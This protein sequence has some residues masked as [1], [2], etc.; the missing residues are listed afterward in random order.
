L[1]S[2]M[3][4][5]D[6]TGT[7]QITLAFGA[8]CVRTITVTAQGPPSFLDDFHAFLDTYTVSGYLAAISVH[9]PLVVAFTR[10]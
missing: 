5:R 1:K 10:P 2:A 3:M 4:D 8:S 6:L 9:I 7:I